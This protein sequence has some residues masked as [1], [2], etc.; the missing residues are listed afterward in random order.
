M[1]S[2]VVVGSDDLQKSKAFYDAIFTASGGNAGEMDPK[3]RLVYSKDGSR[4]LVTQPIDG[5][6]ASCGNGWTI[7]FACASPEEVDAWHSAGVA[8][9]GQSIEN[10]PG[11]REVGTRKLYL[12]YLRDPTGNKLC[13]RALMPA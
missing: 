4:F 2:H 8:N 3:G 1:F 6:A 11:V 12:A 9:G 10:P 5:K 13:A 7:G